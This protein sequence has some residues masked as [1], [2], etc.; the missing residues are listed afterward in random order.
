MIL[1]RSVGK[2]RRSERVSLFRGNGWRKQCMYI[3]W[4]DERTPTPTLPLGT[5][6]GGK[7]L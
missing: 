6:G 1:R 7:I 3:V 5:W 2:R 4:H